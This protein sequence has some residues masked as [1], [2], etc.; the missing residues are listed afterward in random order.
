MKKIFFYFFALPALFLSCGKENVT[1]N[2]ISSAMF[3]NASPSSPIYNVLVDKV[4]QT[5]TALTFRAASS[6]LNIA[7]GSRNINLKSNNTVAPV[8]YV[9]ITDNFANNSASTY[10]AYDILT[11][12]TSPLKYVRFN[13]DL[14]NPRNGFYK[15]RVLPLAIGAPALDF[16]FLRTSTAPAPN[17]SVT[18]SNLAYIGASP[19]ES[20]IAAL[21]KFVELPT[22]S[23][24]IR[25]KLAGTQTLYVAPIAYA[26]TVAGVQRGIYT[27]FLTGNLPTV[28]F[29][30]NVTRNYP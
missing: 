2:T 25:V 27:F 29:A 1:D 28:G 8:D 5:S 19:T 24:S 15:F 9:N 10:A 13:D 12:P 6:Y 3:I 14:S 4:N 26:P 16:T 30:I 18:I 21:S 11:T 17:D 23:Y 20:Q 22:G 7:T